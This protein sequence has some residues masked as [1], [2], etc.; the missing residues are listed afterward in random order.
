MTQ[1][2]RII[3]LDAGGAGQGGLRPMDLDPED[4]ESALPHQNLCL[5]YEDRDLGL[6]VGV[7][8]TTSMKEAFGPYPGD[9]FIWVLEGSF[10]M[11]DGS[12]GA[13]TAG[14]GDAVCFRNGAPVS[15]KQDGYLKKFFMTYLN[16]E[17]PVPELDT[18]QGGVIVIDPKAAL[19]TTSDPDAPVEHDHVAFT[20]DAGNMAMGIW[21]CAAA[22]FEMSPFPVHEFVYVLEGETVITEEDGTVHEFGPGDCFFVPKGTVCQWHIPRYIK[23]YYAGLDAG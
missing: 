12:G 22:T 4:F 3:R 14:Q 17:L 7:W 8:D 23:K 13:V 18:A 6:T 15:W 5:C 19:R 11:L 21:D 1:N 10:A 9:E 2:S 16:P 20:N